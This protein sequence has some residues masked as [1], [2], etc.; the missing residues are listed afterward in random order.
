M[1]LAALRLL[2]SAQLDELLVDGV[3][4]LWDVDYDATVRILEKLANDQAHDFEIY[5]DMQSTEQVFGCYVYYPNDVPSS[6]PNLTYTICLELRGD[7]RFPFPV[8]TRWTFRRV[9]TL[10]DCQ[11]GY[12]IAANGELET[13]FLHDLDPE[14]I[15]PA[16]A[17]YVVVRALIF[18]K[19][20]PLVQGLRM[21][22][23]SFST[24]LE[25]D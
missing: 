25:E 19:K 2:S 9:A 14:K 23:L 3:D 22:P 5:Y 20:F 7:G 18:R 13:I 15:T 6:I 24:K 17:V 11:I 4:L 12:A 21:R 8:N 10:L 1:D 16:L